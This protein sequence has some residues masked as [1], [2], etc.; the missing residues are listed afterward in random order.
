[1]VHLFPLPLLLLPTEAVE[2]EGA[3]ASER[4]RRRWE[5]RTQKLN[6]PSV[7]VVLPSGG[8]PRLLPLLIPFTIAIAYSK[9]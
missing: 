5:I 1:M 7:W 4:I 2:Q 8:K 6:V 3:D 9:V